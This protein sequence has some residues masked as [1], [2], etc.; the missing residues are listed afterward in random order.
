[1]YA[2]RQVLVI[3]ALRLR[4]LKVVQSNWSD[5]LHLTRIYM[6]ILIPIKLQPH[7]VPSC[8][9]S[10]H[11]NTKILL[12][13]NSKS[14]KVHVLLHTYTRLYIYVDI[15]Y[16]LWICCFACEIERKLLNGFLPHVTLA[17][18]QCNLKGFM[19]ISI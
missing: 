7:R 3:C 16:I 15:V 13:V 8:S 1:M 4:L 19:Q 5:S 12:R 11:F 17:A 9:P 14:L 18:Y 2:E 6:F 10:S